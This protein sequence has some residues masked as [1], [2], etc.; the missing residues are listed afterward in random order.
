[1]TSP[2][3]ACITCAQLPAATS[4]HTSVTPYSCTLSPQCSHVRVFKTLSVRL[5]GAAQLVVCILVFVNS[6]RLWSK[7]LIWIAAFNFAAVPMVFT[8]VSNTCNVSGHQGLSSVF[9]RSGYC[10]DVLSCMCNIMPRSH[11]L[12]ALQNTHAGSQVLAAAR[13]NGD[14]LLGTVMG[15]IACSL[16][17]LPGHAFTAYLCSFAFLAVAVSAVLRVRCA[18]LACHGS[19]R[20]S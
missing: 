17:R 11:K 5:Y 18:L 15:G 8:Q 6:I 12:L 7:D 4:T 16:A 9:R 20:H 1:M 3:A 10:I 2:P 19:Q 13:L 14:M